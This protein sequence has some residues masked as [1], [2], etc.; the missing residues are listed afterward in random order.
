MGSS[1]LSPGEQSCNLPPL[2]WVSNQNSIQNMILGDYIG[3]LARSSQWG[4]MVG[5]DCHWGPEA[6]I[7]AGSDGPFSG[8]S[9]VLLECTFQSGVDMEHQGAELDH[10]LYFISGQTERGRGLSMATQQGSNRTEMV[11]PFSGIPSYSFQPSLHLT[12]SSQ[13]GPALGNNPGCRVL[14]W[15]GRGRKRPGLLDNRWRDHLLR[16]WSGRQ[17]Q[18]GLLSQGSLFL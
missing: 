18:V 14:L 2:A 3:R 5:T 16:L 1:R 8:P 11:K 6:E 7:I 4:E 12:V 9:S 13:P 17:V 15:F 10:P